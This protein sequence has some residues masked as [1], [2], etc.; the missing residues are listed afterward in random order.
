M[1]DDFHA[2]VSDFGLSR[3]KEGLIGQTES[4]IGPF[5]Y[6]SPGMHVWGTS[7]LENRT[8]TLE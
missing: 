5:R 2:K 4:G 1:T 8:R 7:V 3:V 6:M